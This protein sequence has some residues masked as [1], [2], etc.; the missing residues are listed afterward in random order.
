MLVTLKPG[1]IVNISPK[2]FI[3][4]LD[5]QYNW[6]SLPEFD[7]DISDL[8]ILSQEMLKMGRTDKSVIHLCRALNNK[9]EDKNFIL[10]LT[11]VIQQEYDNNIFLN[12]LNKTAELASKI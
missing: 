2:E 4:M 10:Y 8:Y 6:T 3:K 5:E 9:L 7:L 12:I 1:G 11:N